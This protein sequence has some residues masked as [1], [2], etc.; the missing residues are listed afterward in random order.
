VS[1][2]VDEVDDLRKLPKV[3]PLKAADGSRGAKSR[4]PPKGGVEDLVFTEHKNGKRRL[5]YIYEGDTYYIEY[6][7]SDRDN[8]FDFTSRTVTNRGSVE[9]GEYCR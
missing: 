8:C 2:S 1:I 7:P 4:K 6:S 5:Q 3:R 9:S